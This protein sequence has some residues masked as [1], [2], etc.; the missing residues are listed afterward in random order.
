MGGWESTFGD[1]KTEPS[2]GKE[3]QKATVD[4]Q[5]CADGEDAGISPYSLTVSLPPSWTVTYPRSPPVTTVLFF[6]FSFLFFLDFYSTD[7]ARVLLP[8]S[9]P[10][11]LRMST[12]RGC[13]G[14]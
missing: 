14:Q 3:Q 1:Q 13:G 10:L 5:S 9:I 4:Q 6:L 12:H 11:Q 7:S 2:V 8:Y